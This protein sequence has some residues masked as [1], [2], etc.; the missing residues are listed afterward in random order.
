MFGWEDVALKIGWS[1]VK[2][3]IKF[4]IVGASNTLISLGVYYLCTF[5]FGF[6][7]Q[8]SN[9]IAFVVSV[10]NAYFW[11][12]HWVFK[13]GSKAALVKFTVIYGSSY[14]I[15]AGLLYVWTE[16]LGIDKAIAPVLSLFITVPYN[17]ILSRLWAFK[18]PKPACE[19]EP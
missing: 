8:L 1:D 17:Y 19:L 12:A 18:P 10:L 2:Q 11:N 14:L 6:V 16:L 7:P 13:Q 4:G 9:F 5:V 15:S 3:F